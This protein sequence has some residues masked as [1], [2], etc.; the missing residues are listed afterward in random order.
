MG[1]LERLA[2]LAV[3]QGHGGGF[4]DVLGD[5]VAAAFVGGDGGGGFVHHDVG[6]QAVNLVFGTD[7]GYQFQD[8]GGY[9]HLLQQLA[10]AG[11]AVSFG[12]FGGLLLRHKAIRVGFVGDAPFYHFLP[13]GGGKVAV[14]FHRQAESIQ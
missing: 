13:F 5:D 12:G 9:F 2:A 1:L 6:P 7:A 11:Y 8:G 4:A 14:R 10:A 3:E